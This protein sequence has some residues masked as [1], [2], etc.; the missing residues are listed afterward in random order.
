LRLHIDGDGDVG[1]AALHD[2]G[3]NRQVN[4]IF[5]VRRIHDALVVTGDINEELI[6]LHVLLGKG[7]GNVLELHA[8]DGE[9]GLL[10]HLRIVETVEKMNA[11]GTGGGET[12]A[13][14]PG[15]LGVGAGH[16][17]CRLFV[18]YVNEA[19]LLLLFAERFHDSVDSIAG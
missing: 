14:T 10:I 8:G 15:E 18:P 7:S 13:E 3:A 9:D 16:E 2:G 5:H 4:H 1:D 11:A 12:H 19:N 17:G 6:E